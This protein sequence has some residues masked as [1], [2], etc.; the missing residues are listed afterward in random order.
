M[1]DLNHDIPAA[2]R[3]WY[4]FDSRQEE[5]DYG[6]GDACYDAGMDRQDWDNLDS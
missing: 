3:E 6:Y 2:P 5:Y 4:A 1:T